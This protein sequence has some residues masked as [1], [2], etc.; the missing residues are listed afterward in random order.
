MKVVREEGLCTHVENGAGGRDK[1]IQHRFTACK[2]TSLVLPRDYQSSICKER[3]PQR[4]KMI[5]LSRTPVNKHQTEGLNLDLL[6]PNPLFY[7]RKT[8]ASASTHIMNLLE[9][10]FFL[11]DVP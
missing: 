9:V 6:A 4:Y 10:C 3:E 7:I 5:Y 11:L 8:K 2:L 1:N